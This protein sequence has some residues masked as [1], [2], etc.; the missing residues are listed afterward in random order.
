MTNFL[1]VTCGTQFDASEAP[2]ARCP[3]CDDERQY[4]GPGGQRWTTLEQLAGDHDN[5]FR[6]LEPGLVGVGTTPSFAIGQRALLVR[7][8]G[9]NVLWDCISLLDDT[10]VELVRALGGISSIAISHPH[11]YS[12]M[13]EWAAAFDATVHLHAGDRQWVMRPDSRVHF[14][15]G[16]SLELGAGMTLLRAGGHFE[17]GTV[18][19]WAGGAEGRGALLSGDILQVVPDRRYVS[20]M[21]SYPNLIPLP[22]PAIRHI[23]QVVAPYA[24]DRIYGAWW[25]RVVESDGKACVGR[26]AARYIAAIGAGELAAEPGGR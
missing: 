22:A 8:P 17:G 4:V 25:D 3:I 15:E 11:Y 10:T 19:H 14:W 2:P 7:S 16:E 9:G 23:E 26:S 13:V 24:F 6:I 20:F 18:M 21:Y 5:V 12:S 1:C